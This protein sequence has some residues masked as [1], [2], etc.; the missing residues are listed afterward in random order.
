MVTISLVSATSVGE[1]ISDNHFGINATFNYQDL[2]SFNWASRD[3]ELATTCY[4]GG[5]ETEKYFDIENPNADFKIDVNG[6]KTNSNGDTGFDLI[7]MD[8]FLSHCVDHNIKPVIV[9]PMT[10]LLT[11]TGA[12]RE[13]FDVAK[14]GILKEFVK[15]ALA[16]MQPVGV[17]SFELGNEYYADMD[18]VTY[19]RVASASAALVQEAIDEFTI[20]QNLGAGYEEPTIAVQIWGDATDGVNAPNVSELDARNA[21]VFGEFD[22]IELAAV[23]AVTSHF[24]FTDGRHSGEANE[25]SYENLDGAMAPM[26]D[27]MAYWQARTAQNLEYL[28]TEWNVHHYTSESIH[29]PQGERIPNPSVG[30]MQ[31]APMLEMFSRFVANGIDTMELWSMQYHN[32]SIASPTGNLMLVGQ[33]FDLMQSNLVG[34]NVLD[35]DETTETTDVHGFSDGETAYIFVSS[36]TGESQLVDLTYGSLFAS[37]SNAVATLLYVDPNSTDGS[38]RDGPNDGIVWTP[39]NEPDANLVASEHILTNPLGG[40]ASFSLGAYEVMMFE[41]SLPV[42]VA[43]LE[44]LTLVVLE[45]NQIG[46]LVSYLDGEGDAAVQYEVWD[47]EGSNNFWLRYIG[48]IDA[49]EGY[50]FSASQLSDLWIQGDSFDSTQTLWIRANDGS[51][52]G[53]WDSFLLTTE[54]NTAPVATLEDVNLVLMEWEPI[55]NSV[56]YSDDDGNAAVQYE[57]WDREGGNSFWIQYTGFV[58][59]SEGYVFDAELLGGLWVQGDGAVGEQAL[60]IRAYDGTDW[61]VWDSFI[62]NTI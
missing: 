19:G 39:S 50:V 2:G 30:M 62:L 33:F 10:D 41:F 56:V 7:P 43:S 12:W 24:Y 59:A 57:I 9:V 47:S 60:W 8:E 46:T 23:D 38:F 53:A 45:W 4:P 27:M 21:N 35:I 13:D 37:Y 16:Q 40:N 61:G 29:S 51:E 36:L 31:V 22:A 54:A 52:W 26:F 55:G 34:M 25:H 6:N 5:A 15:S 11:D 3:I 17:E 42:T 28:V 1:E 48:D 14:S 20:E 18:A 32:T 44:D 58:D 49:S